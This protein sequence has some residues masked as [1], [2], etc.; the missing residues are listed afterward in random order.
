MSC[1]SSEKR[2][3]RH[4]ISYFAGVP[5][6]WFS[7]PRPSKS[8]NCNNNN[9]NNNNNNSSSEK[10]ERER[11]REREKERKREKKRKKPV[12]CL[13]PHRLDDPSNAAGGVVFGVLRWG[14]GPLAK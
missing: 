12:K 11:E 9:N 10:R 4:L 13:A 5:G 8:N 2:R 3:P 6:H 14:N 7:E 1:D